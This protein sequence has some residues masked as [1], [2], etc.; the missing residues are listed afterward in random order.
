MSACA[1]FTAT[2]LQC[3]TD[4]CGFATDPTSIHCQHAVGMGTG[5]PPACQ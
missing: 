2:Q 1:G 3:R 5:V 4:H